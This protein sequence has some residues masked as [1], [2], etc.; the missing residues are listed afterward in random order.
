MVL[1]GSLFGVNGNLLFAS[2]GGVLGT[3]NAFALIYWGIEIEQG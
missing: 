2:L 1:T 3:V